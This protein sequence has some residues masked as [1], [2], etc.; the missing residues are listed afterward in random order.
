M[1][2]AICKQHIPHKL[3]STTRTAKPWIHSNKQVKEAIRRKH[4]LHSKAKRVN[5]DVAWAT[6]KRQRNLVTSLTRRAEAAYIEDL[7]NDV[8]SGNTRRIFTY[9]KSALGKTSTG[10]PALQVG[11]VILETPD[12]KANA[13]NDFFIQQTDLPARDDPTP[14][15]QPTAIPGTVLDSI[16]L[17]VDEV[18]QQLCAL[19]IGK[20]CGPDNITPKLLRLV[21]DPISGPLTQLYNK[22]LVLGQVPSGWKKANVT[23]I[24]KAGNRHLTNNYRPLSLLSIVS[25]VLETLVNKRLTAHVN[26]ILTDHQSGFRPLDNTTLQL[27]RMIEE[28]TEAMDDGDLRKAFDKVWHAGLLSKLRAYG[29]SESMYNWF[30]SYLFER[31]QRVVIQGVASDWKSPLAGVPQGSVPGPTLFILYINDLATSCIQ[32]QPNLF[33]DDTSLSSSHHSIQHV[34]ASLNRDLSSVSTW[35]SQWKLEANIDKCKAMFITTRAIPRPIP[36]VTLGGTT[37]LRSVENE[38]KCGN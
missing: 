21:A 29:I 18:R 30:S 6:Y 17:S 37:L 19:K 23:P 38:N 3:I 28:W 32:S 13:Q 27:A 16:Q 1:F 8:E 20:S 12:E 34:V 22:S 14:T 9:A 7:V 11:S 4:R 2:I 10:T 15:F 26:P 36:P 33:A 24:H 5:T 25:K 31:R 35:L